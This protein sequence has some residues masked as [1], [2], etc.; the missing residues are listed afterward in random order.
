M[1][2]D[3]FT[4]WWFHSYDYVIVLFFNFY[5]YGTGLTNLNDIWLLSVWKVGQ[6]LGQYAQ[7][8]IYRAKKIDLLTKVVK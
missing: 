1:D 2:I 7:R 8:D 4:L 5:C 6:Q 3:S